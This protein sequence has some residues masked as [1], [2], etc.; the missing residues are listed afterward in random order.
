M[1]R[2]PF[3]QDFPTVGRVEAHKDIGEQNNNER[4]G[5]IAEAIDNFV[6]KRF[7][8]RDFSPADNQQRHKSRHRQNVGKDI[9]H[10]VSA[11]DDDTPLRSQRPF[12]EQ[13]PQF[14]VRLGDPTLPIRTSNLSRSSNRCNSCRAS[15]SIS[16]LRK[17][18][19][20]V[21]VLK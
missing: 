1:S 12:L 11:Q 21:W 10:R 7:Q 16:I 6:H 3:Q 2:E 19:A 4:L 14:P 5:A 20:S 13:F 8:H 18:P 15:S 9:L 17:T